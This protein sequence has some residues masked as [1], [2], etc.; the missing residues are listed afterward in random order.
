MNN[1]RRYHVYAHAPRQFEP[2]D[3]SIDADSCDNPH[4]MPQIIL[5]GHLSA[6]EFRQIFG[7]QPN[8]MDVMCSES[9]EGDSHTIRIFADDVL[10][11]DNAN[12]SHQSVLIN[13]LLHLNGQ[14]ALNPQEMY[15]HARDTAGLSPDVLRLLLPAVHGE[16]QQKGMTLD[17]LLQPAATP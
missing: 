16:M 10:T 15:D 12:P 13:H 11:C 9:N 1:P 14:S 4:G 7:S 8:I 6:E 17:N 3:I 5:D 2:A